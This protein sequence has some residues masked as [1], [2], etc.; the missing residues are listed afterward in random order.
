M[1]LLTAE[2]LLHTL[3]SIDG[4]DLGLF[5][6]RPP[7]CVLSGTFQWGPPDDYGRERDCDLNSFFSLKLPGASPQAFLF[8]DLLFYRS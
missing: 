4:G 8:S 5:P 6:Q 2:F 7:P 3:L 1:F